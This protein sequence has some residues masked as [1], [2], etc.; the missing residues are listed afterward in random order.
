[1][2]KVYADQIKDRNVH[3]VEDDYSSYEIIDMPI[4]EFQMMI[5]DFIGKWKEIHTCYPVFVNHI[6]RFVRECGKEW[7]GEEFAIIAGNKEHHFN[8]N[9]QLEGWTYGYFG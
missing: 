6:G 3:Y 5:R 8:D 4:H 1:M 9:G 7:Y 2:I